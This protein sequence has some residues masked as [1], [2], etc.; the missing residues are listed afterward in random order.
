MYVQWDV[1]YVN[2]NEVELHDSICIIIKNKYKGRKEVVEEYVRYH[3][4]YIN[5]NIM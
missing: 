2:K 3:T 4:F 5:L 1:T